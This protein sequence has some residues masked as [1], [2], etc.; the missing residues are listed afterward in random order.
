MDHADDSADLFQRLEAVAVADG[1]AA[2]FDMLADSLV[3]SGRW[4]AL[5]DLRLVQARAAL[6]LPSSGDLA[7]IDAAQRDA[8]DER[9]LAA[10]REVGWPLLRAGNVAAGWMYLRAAAEP[11]DVAAALAELARRD[12]PAAGGEPDDEAAEQRRQEIV[13]IALW[14]S[15]DPSLGLSLVLASQGTCNAITAYE[16]AVARLPA[17]RQQ[18]PA[19]LLVNHLH[20]ELRRALAADLQHRGLITPAATAEATSITAL[21]AA[22]GGLENDPSVHVDVSHLQSVLR[23][24]R[25]CTDRS[26]IEKAWQLAAY[27]CRLPPDAV[28]PGEPPF[29]DVGMASRLFFGAHLGRDVDEAVR[30]FHRAAATA[31]VEDSG[32]LPADALVLLLQRLGRPTKAC[33]A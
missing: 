26:V 17:S 24:A 31:R 9:S 7:G 27:A 21:L 28:Y 20:G 16:Q 15:I 12:P 22:A 14:E 6:G 30:Y 5:F 10:C 29:A 11:G 4:H 33:R 1:R 19:E 32:T 8:L 25:V 3:K 23:I 2:M 13:H 18:P